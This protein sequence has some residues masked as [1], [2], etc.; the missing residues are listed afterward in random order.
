MLIM[1]SM[2]KIISGIQSLY[3]ISNNAEIKTENGFES[4]VYSVLT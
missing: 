1:V 4:R 2:K 3:V